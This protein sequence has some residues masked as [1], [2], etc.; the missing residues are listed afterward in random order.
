MNQ[1]IANRKRL[2][3]ANTRNAIH[4][5]ERE[6]LL[7]EWRQPQ[8]EPEIVSPLMQ[9]LLIIVMVVAA[10]LLFAGRVGGFL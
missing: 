9:N 2:H 4:A 10:V 7:R 3:Q 8:P 1:T 5:V 6:R